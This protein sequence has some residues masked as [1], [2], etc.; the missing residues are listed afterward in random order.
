MNKIFASGR[1]TADPVVKTING[2]TC[3]EFT[4]AS[5]TRVKKQDGEKLANFWR[6][7]AW[8]QLA[9]LCSNYL[10]KGDKISIVGDVALRPY[11][12][13]KGNERISPDVTVSDLEFGEK[14]STNGNRVQ[15]PTAAPMPGGSSDDL[16]F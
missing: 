11:T 14:K 6:C 13:T 1:L 15:A 10:H 12:D 3:A 4:L 8:R 16:P 7:T 2:S 9:E 5:D